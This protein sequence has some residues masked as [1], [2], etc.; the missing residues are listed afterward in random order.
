MRIK[1]ADHE[2]ACVH[3]SRESGKAASHDERKRE[4]G[5]KEEEEEEEEAEEEEEEKCIAVTD[6]ARHARVWQ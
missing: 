1:R 2:A 4:R 5:R 6:N 3:T